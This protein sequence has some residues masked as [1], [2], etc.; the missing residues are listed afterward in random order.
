MSKQERKWLEAIVK[1][2][3]VPQEFVYDKWAYDR[4]RNCY[5]KWIEN[6]LKGKQP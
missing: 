6:V 4:M 1:Y 2:K 3:R 5:K